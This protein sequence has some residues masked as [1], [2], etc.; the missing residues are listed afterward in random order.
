MPTGHAAFPVRRSRIIFSYVSGSNHTTYP[1]PGESSTGEPHHM[2]APPRIVVP[3]AIILE[4]LLGLIGALLANWQEV[5]LR[6]LLELGP[7]G[8]IRGLAATLPMLAM[9][10]VVARSNWPP[11][12]QLRR[13]V[14]SLTRQL[15]ATATWWE[16][17][18]ISAAA[19]IGEEIL[20]RGA[21]QPIVSGWTTPIAG[22]A[23][24]SVAFGLAHAASPA[25]FWLATAVGAYLGWL[26][27]YYHDLIAPII[28][29]GLYDFIA[30]LWLQRGASSS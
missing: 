27:L 17:A 12:A 6:E 7:S 8:A 16:L 21:L 23:I 22:L 4:L 1:Y 5:P 26:T 2:A 18:L 28:A 25:Y 11:L 29:H 30:L 20:F 14:R 10:V 3:I 13:Q 15:F 19:G 9:L 24:V